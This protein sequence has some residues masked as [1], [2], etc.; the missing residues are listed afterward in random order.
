[1][2]HTG[3]HVREKEKDR[4]LAFLKP[5]GGKPGQNMDNGCLGP[6]DPGSPSPPSLVHLQKISKMCAVY[7]K[8]QREY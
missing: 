4:L 3:E 1:L 2:A 7:V 6:E 5:S 8:W